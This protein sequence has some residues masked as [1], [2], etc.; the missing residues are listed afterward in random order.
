MPVARRTR[1]A[2]RRCAESASTSSRIDA[3]GV[4]PC[5]GDP[6]G[7]GTRNNAS[8]HALQ[9][10]R[11]DKKPRVLPLGEKTAALL[12]RWRRIPWWRMSSLEPQRGRRAGNSAGPLCP[13]TTKAESTS[14]PG[15]SRFRVNQRGSMSLAP[16]SSRYRITA[17]VA[18]FSSSFAN[19][20]FV[21]VSSTR[22]LHTPSTE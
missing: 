21:G 22:S 10:P 6:L 2:V 12:S 14:R 9:R 13:S 5:I 18:A 4:E 16:C 19:E 17:R 8:I 3:V 1:W 7:R 20:G 11:V 15:Q